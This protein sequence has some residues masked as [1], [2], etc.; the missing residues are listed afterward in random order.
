MSDERQPG[1]LPSAKLPP[2]VREFLNQVIQHSL[3][4]FDILRFFYHNPYAILTISD[5]TIWMSLE[6]RPLAESLQQ[7]A[8]LGLLSQSHASSAFILTTDPERRRQ[9][10]AFFGYLEENPELAR[11]LRHELRRRLE[12]K[13]DGS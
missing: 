11:Q 10:T 12:T 6:E 1:E 13:Q 4:R 3:M 7:L 8:A 2:A 5:M 9:L